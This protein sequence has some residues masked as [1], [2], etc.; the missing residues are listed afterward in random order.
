MKLSQT[1]SH[2]FSFVGNTGI[3]SPED[4]DSMFIRNIGT[5]L[6]GIATSGQLHRRQN[7]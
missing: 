2:N 4:G 7:F 6:H 3:F 5:N 1:V